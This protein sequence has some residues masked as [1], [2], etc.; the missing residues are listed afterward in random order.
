MSATPGILEETHIFDARR[1]RRSKNQTKHVF[2]PLVTCKR[3]SKKFSGE[4]IHLSDEIEAANNAHGV[5]GAAIAS[6]LA[7]GKGIGTSESGNS[8]GTV[9]PACSVTG[10]ESSQDLS[11]PPSSASEKE[12]ERGSEK[13][14]VSEILHQWKHMFSI[15][16]QTQYSTDGF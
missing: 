14:N 12:F 15:Q 1:T 5:S 7:N 11:T 6:A 13:G 4:K 2:A 3:K 16:K 10:D 9:S 8:S